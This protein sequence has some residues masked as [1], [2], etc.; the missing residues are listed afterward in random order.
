[1]TTRKGW[2]PC[3]GWMLVRKSETDERLG[4][5]VI[6]DAARDRMAGWVYDVLDSGGPL[7]PEPDENGKVE[8]PGTPHPLKPGDWVLCPP[9]QAMECDD[10]GLLLLPEAAVWAVIQ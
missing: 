5:L 4:S 1:M 8:D 7:D 3:P 2:S 9:R 6:P 10:E